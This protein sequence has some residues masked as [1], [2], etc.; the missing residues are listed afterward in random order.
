MERT[1]S[2][3]LSAS[4]PNFDRSRICDHSPELNTAS[5]SLDFQTSRPR[6]SSCANGLS[7]PNIYPRKARTVRPGCGCLASVPFSLPL[8]SDGGG[9]P[10]PRPR[11]FLAEVVLLR[12]TKKGVAVF[13]REYVTRRKSSFFFTFC[14]SHEVKNKRY[15]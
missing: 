3:L 7:R 13:A 4:P 9:R 8:G 1:A 15:N 14:F 2:V 6:V 12:R 11:C 5:L 10:R